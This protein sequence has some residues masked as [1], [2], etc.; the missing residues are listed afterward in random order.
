MP[1]RRGSDVGLLFPFRMV[2]KFS[3]KIL[4]FVHWVETKR[5]AICVLVSF[6]KSHESYAAFD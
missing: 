2:V 3:F 5:W 1:D 6:G 4:L